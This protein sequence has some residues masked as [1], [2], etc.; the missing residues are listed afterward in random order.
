MLLKLNDDIEQ[1]ST[2]KDDS[3]F[4]SVMTNCMCIITICLNNLC[5]DY[6][7]VQQL[8]INLLSS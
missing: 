6:L 1:M 4:L 8:Y 5:C 2:L 3:S 7:F